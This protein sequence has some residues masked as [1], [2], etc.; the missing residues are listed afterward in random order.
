MDELFVN[1]L[2]NVKVN[3]KNDNSRKMICIYVLNI[4]KFLYFFVFVEVFDWGVVLLVI[5]FVEVFDFRG[6]LL[7]F[8]KS[9]LIIRIEKFMIVDGSNGLVFF[10]VIVGFV[11]FCFIIV[12]FW[13]VLKKKFVERVFI[14]VFMFV[15]RIGIKYVFL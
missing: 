6:V 12:V 8:V 15:I 7:V 14:N 2:V 3:K 13:V 4:M 10:I 9:K 1:S 11:L 5:V